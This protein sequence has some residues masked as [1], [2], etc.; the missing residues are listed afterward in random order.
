[1]A[2]VFGRFSNVN[3]Y[4]IDV[5]FAVVGQHGTENYSNVYWRIIGRRLGGSSGYYSGNNSNN[6]VI[7]D[8]PLG[9]V[10][11]LAN[12]SGFGY[13]FQAGVGHAIIFAEGTTRVNHNAAGDASFWLAGQ[14]TLVSLGT[15]SA[16]TGTRNLPRISKPPAKVLNVR[17]SEVLPTSVRISWNASTD[18]GG[19]AIVG[20]LLRMWPNA[21]GTGNYTDISDENN[22]SRVVTGL[23][24]GQEYRFAVFARNTSGHRYSPQS[25]AHVVRTLSGM[26]VKV[27]GAW[28]L[29]VPYVKVNGAW[30]LAMPFL[31]VNGAWRRTG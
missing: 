18:N 10:N 26:R 12:S 5:D 16:N 13:N 20:Y 8:S 30:K 1:M 28:R 22:L 29:A 7:A 15:A 19:S 31:K 23:T 2:P 3:Y 17:S 6:K 25:D 9:G 11:D 24:P 27:N 4:E 21:A 14:L